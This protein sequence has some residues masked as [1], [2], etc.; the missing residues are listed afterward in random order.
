MKFRQLFSAAFL[1]S[2]ASFAFGKG[3]AI[4]V[5]KEPT[6]EP[7]SPSALDFKVQDINGKETDL[8]QFKGKVVLIINVASRCGN[9]PQYK[10]MEAIYKKYADKGFVILG[11]PA[12][13]YGH[14]EPGTNDQIKEFCT[15]TYDV[16]FPMMAKISTMG[17]DKAPIYKFLTEMPTAGDFAGDVE[18]NFTKFLVDRNGNLIARFANG[19]KPEDPKVTTEIEKAIAAKTAKADKK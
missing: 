7:A 5:T 19:I 14:Q 1:L 15:S 2:L 12:N 6:N 8:S 3:P 17:A 4:T 18:W 10:G 16:T 11:F 13:N 9:T